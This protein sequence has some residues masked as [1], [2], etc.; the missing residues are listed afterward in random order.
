MTNK[1]G[2]SIFTGTQ[3]CPFFYIFSTAFTLKKQNRV[4][5]TEATWPR[6]KIFTICPVTEKI[7]QSLFYN[8]TFE[9]FFPFHVKCKLSFDI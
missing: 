3:P 9:K 6:S 1:A 2:L 4:V 7:C 8:N 5:A